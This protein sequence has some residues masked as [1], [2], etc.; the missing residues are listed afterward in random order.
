[1]VSTVA[2]GT[3]LLHIATPFKLDNV[4]LVLLGIALLPWLASVLRRAELPGGLKF[5]FQEIKAEQA[6]QARELDAIKFLIG[7]FLTAPEQDHLE[8]IAKKTPFLVK[9]NKTSSFFATELRKLRALG[10]IKQIG[11]GGV[12]SLLQDDGKER[13]VCA[14][15]EITQRGREYIQLRTEINALDSNQSAIKQPRGLD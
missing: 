7:N 12:R 6:R 4:A 9:A 15:F 10:F 13:N 11:E 5:E 14:F 8:K 3:A 2:L 1:M